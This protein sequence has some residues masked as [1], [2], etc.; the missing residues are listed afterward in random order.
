MSAAVEI[1][2]KLYATLRRMAGFAPAYIEDCHPKQRAFAEDRSKR[3]CALTSRRGGKSHVIGCWLLEGGEDC[4]RGKSLFIALTRGKAKSIL[5]DDCLSGLNEKYH[6]GLRLKHDEGQLYVFMPNGHRI[7]LLGIDNQS[8]VDKVRGERLRRAV[9]DEAQA[10]G[11]YLDVLIEEAIEPALMDLQGEL[12]LTGT[13]SPLAAGYFWAATTGGDPTIARWPTHHWTV[14]DN[15]YLPHARAWLEETKTRNNWDDTHPRYRREFLGEWTEDIGSLVY[16]L[17]GENSWSPDGELPFG[18]PP[19]E[20]S[21]GLGVDLGFSLHSTAF[22]LIAIRR[23]TGQVFVLSAY[24]RSRLIPTA[25]AAHVQGVREMVQK[26]AGV[27]GSSVSVVGLRVVVDEGAL[28]KGYAEQ[29]RVMGVA[30]EPA[31]KTE[32]RAYQEYVRGLVLTGHR[33]E[34][35]E[36]GL[37]LGGSGLLIDFAKCREL[38]SECSKLQ[39]DEETGQEDER[40][41]RHCADAM[42]YIVRAMQPTYEPKENE[43]KPGSP[44]ALK[45]EMARVRLQTIKDRER[46]KR[47]IYG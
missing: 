4:P 1:P 32:K 38:I 33:P 27:T 28:G 17:T 9:I 20:Y 31:Q 26:E 44:E 39:F 23:G 25:L 2:A 15:V 45:A 10:F 24:T 12:A 37:F 47:G 40:Y 34:R 16:P 14:L 21:Y 3:K 30:C 5:W 35:G 41:V 18:L 7:W 11:S 19:G 6:L 29:M 22:V 42:L 8:E 46:R 13:P 43:P 36:D